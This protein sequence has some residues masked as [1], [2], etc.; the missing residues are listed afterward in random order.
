MVSIGRVVKGIFCGG[1]GEGDFLS[2]EFVLVGLSRVVKVY[3]GFLDTFPKYYLPT[4]NFIH[5]RLVNNTWGFLFVDIF[6]VV[7]VYLGFLLVD[8]FSV[9][10]VYLGFFVS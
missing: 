1:G 10:N 9:F 7:K 5:T 8:T 3:S 4:L 6:R 2:C